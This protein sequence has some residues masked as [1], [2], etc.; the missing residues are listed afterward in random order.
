MEA[1]KLN[2]RVKIL[3]RTATRDTAGGQSATFTPIAEVWASID[4]QYSALTYETSTFVSKA[5]YRIALRYDKTLKLSVS[6]RIENCD[7][8][9]STP[10]IY[11]IQSIV[12]P[13][14]RNEQ[15]MLLCYSLDDPE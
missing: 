11:E 9:T 10:H 15:L 13:A 5:T 6:D 3:R 8:S 2:R 7:P 12:N 4:I 1:G 14:Q